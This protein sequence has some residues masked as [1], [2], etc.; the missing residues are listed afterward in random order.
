MNSSLICYGRCSP[1]YIYCYRIIA[2][3]LNGVQMLTIDIHPIL[4]IGQSVLNMH[5]MHI[6]DVHCHRGD[7]IMKWGVVKVI[8]WTGEGWEGLSS[9]LLVACNTTD[10][11]L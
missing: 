6:N 10:N 11:D 9:E 3:G 2:D 1:R 7:K 8:S 4:S 5:N